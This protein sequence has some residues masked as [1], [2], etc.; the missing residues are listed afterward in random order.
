V[1]R[2]PPGTRRQPAFTFVGG[3]DVPLSFSKTVANTEYVP[4]FAYV[5]VAVQVPVSFAVKLI[6]PGTTLPS[7]KLIVQLVALM[8]LK[9]AVHVNVLLPVFVHVGADDFIVKPFDPNELLARVRR[10]VTR[11]APS[12]EVSGTGQAQAGHLTPREQEV[13]Q[14]LADG[15]RPKEIARRLSLSAKTVAAHIQRML[16]KFGLH[17]RAE[18]IAFAYRE[19]L[20]EPST[21]AATR[22]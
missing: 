16:E 11:P 13:L 7:P 2:Q 15:L 9:V 20:V 8:S 1:R 12:Q 18:L 5:C 4:F 14:L 19:R 6:V 22:R 21:S 17:S 3:P 10:F